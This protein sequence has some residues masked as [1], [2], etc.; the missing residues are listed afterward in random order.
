[1]HGVLVGPV[2]K[3]IAAAAGLIVTGAIA[4]GFA[5]IGLVYL[6][7]ALAAW[8]TPQTGLTVALLICAGA[9]LAIALL[10]GALMYRASQ[11]G[12]AGKEA[13]TADPTLAASEQA[14]HLGLM[15]VDA[16]RGKVR[17]NP[18]KATLI[19][20]AAGVVLGANPK[21]ARAFVDFSK[22]VCG[23]PSKEE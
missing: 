7:Q 16:L 22:E 13:D 6:W 2:K 1:M 17:E 19:A 18:A 12:P 23:P 20:A 14:F 3:N 11:K 4:F 21:L 15:A 9:A 10:L 8:L 5:V